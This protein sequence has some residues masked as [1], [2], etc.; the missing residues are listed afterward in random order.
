MAASPGTLV[1]SEHLPS[2]G[3]L[4]LTMNVGDVHIVPSPEADRLRVEIHA[5]ASLKEERSWVKQFEVAGD[6]ATVDIQGPKVHEHCVSCYTNRNIIVFVPQQTAIKLQ[7]EIGDV[8]IK[9]VKG[10]KQIRLGIGDLSIGIGD[11]N[12]YSR[13]DL[14]TR[15]GDLDDPVY[16]SEPHGFLGKS[17]TVGREGRYHL[18]AHVGIG[19]L[20]LLQEKG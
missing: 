12:E 10:D 14:S 18:R 6:R 4:V 5:D 1:L 17:E 16:H 8:T 20:K 3:T 11:Q 9:S 7:V 2:N 15:I 19:D 13:I